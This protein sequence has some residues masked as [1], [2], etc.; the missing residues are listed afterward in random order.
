VSLLWKRDRGVLFAG[1]IASNMFGLGYMLGYNDL[2]VGKTSLAKVAQRDF[3]V[4]VFGHGG[5]ITSGPPVNSRKSSDS[6]RSQ[7]QPGAGNPQL[8]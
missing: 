4:A 8:A 5:P 7:S 6:V 2:A 1:D 3:E